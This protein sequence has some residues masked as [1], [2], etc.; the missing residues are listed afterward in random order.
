MGRF[1]A[2]VIVG[3]A[4]GYVLGARAG[5]ERYEQIRRAWRRLESSPT[6]RRYSSKVSAAVGLSLERGRYAAVDG[7]HRASDAVRRRNAS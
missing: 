6:Y 1:K 2:G 4:T 3:L 7:V 5:R